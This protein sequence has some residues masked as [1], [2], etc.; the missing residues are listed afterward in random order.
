MWSKLKVIHY[1]IQFIDSSPTM[2]GAVVDLDLHMNQQLCPTGPTTLVHVEEVSRLL[3]ASLPPRPTHAI[4]QTMQTASTPYYSLMELT[5]CWILSAWTYGVTA[6]VVG[7]ILRSEM[8]FQIPQH[9]W[10]N[11]VAMQIQ[12]LSNQA[13]TICGWSKK[14]ITYKVSVKNSSYQC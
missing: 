10:T 4:I 5:F 1:D 9:S 2:L 8:D 7:I 11:F 13:V 3:T 14:D 12:L 6:P